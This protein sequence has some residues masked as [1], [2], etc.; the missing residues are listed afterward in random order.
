MTPLKTAK[1]LMSTVAAKVEPPRIVNDRLVQ[2]L[3]DKVTCLHSVN[4]RRCNACPLYGKDLMESVTVVK[5]LTVKPLTAMIQRSLS[6]ENTVY[7]LFN[8]T[9]D[10]VSNMYGKM[11][12]FMNKFQMFVHK[13]MAVPKFELHCEELEELKD[14]ESIKVRQMMVMPCLQTP[15]TRLIQYDCGKLQVLVSAWYLINFG[16]I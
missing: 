14:D 13:V 7:D 12:L 3:L 8:L 2:N 6:E 10:K 9:T 5:P 1:P 15:E 11:G 4:E 16:F